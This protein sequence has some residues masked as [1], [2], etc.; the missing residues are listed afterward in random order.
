MMRNGRITI[1]ANEWYDFIISGL[2]QI[3]WLHFDDISFLMIN[4]LISLSVPGITQI[5]QQVI[6]NFIYLDLFM[7]EKW[8]PFDDP[9]DE[10][11]NDYF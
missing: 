2:I 9:D 7:T 3:I 4:T 8:L 10:P 1:T 11:L 5:V 6:V